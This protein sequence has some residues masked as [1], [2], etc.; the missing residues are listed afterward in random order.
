MIAF[1][2]DFGYIDPYVGICKG[3]ISKIDPQAKV[4]DLTHG[5]SPQN[6]LQASL[7]LKASLRQFPKDTIF[8]AVVDPG[9]GTK[10][11]E[12]IVKTKDYSFVGP[13]NGLFTQVYKEY[14]DFICY[15]IDWDLLKKALNP[16]DIEKASPSNTFHARDIFAPAAALLS[17][18]IDIKKIAI[19]KKG[20]EFLE[21]PSV[22]KENST[23]IGQIIYFDHFGN[24]I[25][26]ITKKDIVEYLDKKN[27][28]IFLFIKDKNLQI[29]FKNT[30]LEVEKHKPLCLIGSFDHL[31]ISVNCGNAKKQL[32]LYEGQE[33]IL[34]TMA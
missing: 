26:N 2:T 34:H 18:G 29:P 12:I 22:K 6:L 3:V 7:Y 1:L 19:E 11:E 30:Y 14:P 33:I 10:R 20:V 23:I 27:H 15:K 24:G 25:T 16:F 9:V 8:L 28:E 17:L 32:G 21:I 31:E 13:D 5:V 4:V